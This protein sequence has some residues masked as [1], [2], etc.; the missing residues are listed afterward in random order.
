MAGREQAVSV[1][2]L[3][4]FVAAYLVKQDARRVDAAEKLFE[5]FTEREQQLIKEAAVLG[6]VQGV[7]EADRHRGDRQILLTVLMDAQADT[8]KFPA[9]TGYEPEPEPEERVL[10]RENTDEI[11]AWC[12]GWAAGGARELVGFHEGGL[13]SNIIY[14]HPGDTIIIAEGERPRIVRGDGS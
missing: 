7:Y 10:T 4:A 13:G 14:A 11:A 5:K 8:D 6:Y 9:L 3:K 1:P 2:E 12:G